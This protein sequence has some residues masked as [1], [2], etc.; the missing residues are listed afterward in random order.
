VGG[1]HW[2]GVGYKKVTTFDPRN[3][4]LTPGVDEFPAAVTVVVLVL[5]TIFVD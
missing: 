2:Y 5:V 1:V 4:P 3:P